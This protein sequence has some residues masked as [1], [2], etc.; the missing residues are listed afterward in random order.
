MF[1]GILLFFGLV[2]AAILGV[3]QVLSDGSFLRYVDR[4]PD[5]RWVPATVY[6]LGQGYASIHELAQATTYF[7]RVADQYPNSDYADDSYAAYLNC[8]DTTPGKGRDELISEHQKYLERFPNGRHAEMI[9][10]RIDIYRVR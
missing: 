9:R 2:I 8:L 7:L 4:N 3:H 1:N 5:P 6:Y 10:N